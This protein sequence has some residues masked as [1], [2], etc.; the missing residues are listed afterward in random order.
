M[1]QPG[2][3]L[4][5]I[6]QRFGELFETAAESYGMVKKD[7]CAL[8][9]EAVDRTPD[10]LSAEFTFYYKG[11]MLGKKLRLT[12]K[13][14]SNALA[15]DIGRLLEIIYAMSIPEEQEAEMLNL[16]REETKLEFNYPPTITGERLTR[17]DDQSE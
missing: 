15:T 14:P 11:N 8:V 16:I 5:Y 7:L 10:V 6:N 13:S 1:N 17:P 12:V 4:E 2:I 9:G 3:K